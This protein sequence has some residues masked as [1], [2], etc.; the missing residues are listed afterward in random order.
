MRVGVGMEF[1][2][3]GLLKLAVVSVTRELRTSRQ[4]MSPLEGREG[5]IQ[6]R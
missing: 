2:N 6:A 4:A 5:T 1:F 3:S